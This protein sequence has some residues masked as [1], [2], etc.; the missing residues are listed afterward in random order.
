MGNGNE[1]EAIGRP[2][3]DGS[4]R[5]DAAPEAKGSADAAARPSAGD[6]VEER[7]LAERIQAER[8]EKERLL[9]ALGR[10]ILS[11]EKDRPDLLVRYQGQIAAVTEVAQRQLELQERL[12]VLRR[13][14]SGEQG[15]ADAKDAPGG[16]MAE[17]NMPEKKVISGTPA[18]SSG[19]ASPRGRKPIEPFEIVPHGPCDGCGADALATWK[20]CP[21]CGSNLEKLKAAYRRCPQCGAYYDSH[22]DHCILCG[23]KLEKLPVAPP[24]KVDD[25]A[26]VPDEDD[27][28][29]KT[30]TSGD[31][32]GSWSDSSSEKEGSTGIDRS[33][34][35]RREQDE[36]ALERDSGTVS[37]MPV[38]HE[39]CPAC[40]AYVLP[41]TK[42][43]M[44]CGEDLRG[45][46]KPVPTMAPCPVCGKSN[47]TNARFCGECGASFVQRD[48]GR[49]E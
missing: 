9:A 35:E 25:K 44:G 23:S 24:R 33:S 8:E 21:K 29:K 47:P 26:D 34:D 2:E 20:V 7:R 1:M 49:A 41:H 48:P 5:V 38:F 32:D 42:F 14:R 13:E 16:K 31:E 36:N 43:C 30:D 39:S 19:D 10:A 46:W 40:G 45:P 4:E 3:T 22:A 17:D 37:A 6:S 27:L 28:K 15:S 18:G 11:G 12:A